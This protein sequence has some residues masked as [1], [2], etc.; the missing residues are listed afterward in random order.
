MISFVALSGASLSSAAETRGDR[1]GICARKLNWIDAHRQEHHRLET[2]IVKQSAHVEA[3]VRRLEFYEREVLKP[4]LPDMSS[5]SWFGA[6][7][8]DTSVDEVHGP[9]C[10]RLPRSVER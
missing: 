1:T 8:T 7:V 10:S 5:F 4:Y 3:D 2:V 9:D 6:W